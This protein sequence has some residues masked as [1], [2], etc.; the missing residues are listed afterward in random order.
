MRRL[1]RARS[2]KNAFILTG[3]DFYTVLAR[4]IHKIPGLRVIPAQTTPACPR[5]AGVVFNQLAIENL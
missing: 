5:Q 1:S 4:I 2:L 3:S